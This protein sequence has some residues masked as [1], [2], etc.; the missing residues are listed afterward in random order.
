[1]EKPTN[2]QSRSCL[3]FSLITLSVMT[4]ILCNG[5]AV[6]EACRSTPCNTVDSL[7][8]EAY[9]CLFDTLRDADTICLDCRYLDINTNDTSIQI[10]KRQYQ[11]FSGTFIPLF[12]TFPLCKMIFPKGYLTFLFHYYDANYVIMMYLEAICYSPNGKIVSR[13]VFPAWI[14]SGGFSQSESST[15]NA[16]FILSQSSLVYSWREEPCGGIPHDKNVIIHINQQDG[17]FEYDG[18]EASY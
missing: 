8:F 12:Q 1:M 14:G 16:S 17:H 2:T 15:N 6:E 11:Q 18:K 10:G 5:C 13:E 4:S 9:L 7:S 3:L